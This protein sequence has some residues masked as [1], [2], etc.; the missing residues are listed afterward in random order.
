MHF[1]NSFLEHIIEI[2]IILE[3]SNVPKLILNSN[4]RVHEK[5]FY[6]SIKEQNLNYV[7]T[8]PCIFG[9]VVILQV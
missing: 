1:P 5:S 7:H 6:Q 4:H 3:G 2:S 8:P 9:E